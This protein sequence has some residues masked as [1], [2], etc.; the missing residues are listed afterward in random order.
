MIELRWMTT[1]YN[2]RAGPVR[3][4]QF[5]RIVGSSAEPPYERIWSEWENIPEVRVDSPHIDG[6]EGN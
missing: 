4:L 1:V 3:V 6:S 2:L 5:R